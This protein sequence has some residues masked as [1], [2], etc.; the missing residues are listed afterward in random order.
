MNADGSVSKTTVSNVLKVSGKDNISDVSNLTDITNLSGDE[1]FAKDD[2]GKL[3]W[4][5]KGNDISYQGTTT[6]AAPIDISIKYYLDEKEISAD[7][8]AGKS[9]KV[10]IVYHYNNNAKDEDENVVPFIVLTGMVLN[11]NFTNITVDN[12]K[13]VEFNGSNIVVGYAAPELKDTLLKTIDNADE[14]I[15]DIDIPESVTVTADVKE[16]SLDM[17]LTVATSQV[18]D[19]ELSDTL[20]FSDIKDKMDELED[21]ANQ[22]VDGAGKL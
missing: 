15:G 9:G 20:D 18:G 17:A 6:E 11:E 1:L 14:Y 5:N 19:V 16:F 7:E 3:I 2:N 13:V 12:G 22:L 10:K 8:L 21:G 4:E